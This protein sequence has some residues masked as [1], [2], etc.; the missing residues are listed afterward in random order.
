V[1][2]L[3][4]ISIDRQQVLFGAK[5]I[6]IKPRKNPLTWLNGECWNDEM[7]GFAKIGEEKRKEQERKDKLAREWM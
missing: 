1:V 2:L 4:L 6:N 5:I 3:V 7:E